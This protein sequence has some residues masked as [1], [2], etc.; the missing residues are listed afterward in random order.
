MKIYQ[1]GMVIVVRQKLH[2]GISTT[3]HVEWISWVPTVQA[4]LEHPLFRFMSQV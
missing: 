1:S 2:I 4:W 3:C